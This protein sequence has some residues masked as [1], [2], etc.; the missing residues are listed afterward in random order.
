MQF[1]MRQKKWH[2]P[3]HIHSHRLWLGIVSKQK[4]YTFDRYFIFIYAFVSS[5][6][7]FARKYSK[8]TASDGTLR[9]KCYQC[10]MWKSARPLYFQIILIDSLIQWTRFGQKNTN[11]GSHW[12]NK[13]TLSSTAIPLSDFIKWIVLIFNNINQVHSSIDCSFTWVNSSFD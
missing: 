9:N 8:L 11:F 12:Q 6:G 10:F 7:F 4:R 1:L 3:I 13:Y 5:D 2:G